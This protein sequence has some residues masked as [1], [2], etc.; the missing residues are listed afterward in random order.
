VELLVTMV[1]GGIAL[2]LVVAICLRE[3]RLFTDLSEQSAAY[4]QLRD[5]EAIV[6][7]DV[8][9]AS[10]VAGDV[11]EGRETI[12]ALCIS[13]VRG[14]RRISSTNSRFSRS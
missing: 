5:A 3:Q 1:V 7:I 8:R 13:A 9:G 10:S 4:A 12:P 14:T 11:R 6:P 2:S